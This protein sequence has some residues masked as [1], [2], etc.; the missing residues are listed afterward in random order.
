MKDELKEEIIS[1]WIEMF[2]S[3]KRGDDVSLG[4][5]LRTEGLMEAASITDSWDKEDQYRE[6]QLIYEEI[7]GVGIEKLLGEDWRILHHFPE[8]PAYTERAPVF[9]SAPDDT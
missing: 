8:I 2:S 7:F 9:P 5:R 3:L 1:R 6:L 4:R